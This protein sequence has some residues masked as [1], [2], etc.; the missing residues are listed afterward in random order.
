MLA[1]PLHSHGA[2]RGW[3]KNVCT[4][5]S[6]VKLCD[7]YSTNITLT[8]VIYVIMCTYL[9]VCMYIASSISNDCKHVYIHNTSTCYHILNIYQCQIEHE[10]YYLNQACAS[11]RP[12]C[13][14]L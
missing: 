7:T 14:V 6:C 4:E 13:L 11:L 2:N 12:G 3:Y 9:Y 1:T 5:L 8:D 10:C